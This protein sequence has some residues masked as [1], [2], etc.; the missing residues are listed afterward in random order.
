MLNMNAA[1]HC[2]KEA[3]KEKQ[4][5]QYTGTAIAQI[6]RAVAQAA[7]NTDVADTCTIHG[8]IAHLLGTVVASA[9]R[10]EVCAACR[11]GGGGRGDSYCCCSR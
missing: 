2:P 11:C 6:G 8:S 9:W 1:P 4:Q 5:L 10:R 7:Q 3:C